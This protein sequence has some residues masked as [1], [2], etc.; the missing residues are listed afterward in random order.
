MAPR[1]C[2]FAAVKWKTV[3]LVFPFPSVRNTGSERCRV[4]S[5]F[6]VAGGPPFDARG[7]ELR[8][9]VG[10]RLEIGYDLHPVLLLLL[11]AQIPIWVAGA[12]TGILN[13]Q[14]RKSLALRGIGCSGHR[15]RRPSRLNKR[16]ET[17]VRL[18]T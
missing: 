9:L 17:A 13:Y 8:K 12:P 2:W 6:V 11:I 7:Q 14:G 4:D 18:K 5:R 15:Q 1:N 3:G 10:R 16:M